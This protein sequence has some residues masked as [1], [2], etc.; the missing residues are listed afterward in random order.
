MELL[1]AN[2]PTS[3]PSSPTTF[4]ESD[5]RNCSASS[6]RK[7]MIMWR[8]S[9]GP[10]S[11]DS[12]PTPTRDP[13]ASKPAA[14]CHNRCPFHQRASPTHLTSFYYEIGEWNARWGGRECVAGTPPVTCHPSDTHSSH[15]PLQPLFTCNTKSK[16]LKHQHV[17]ARAFVYFSLTD[18]DQKRW[19]HRS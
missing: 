16:Y 12:Y 5:P 7:F 4:H 11:N 9:H 13:G 6:N 8:D 10:A 19:R 3:R 17:Y 18:G 15:N 2:T 14:A 1:L